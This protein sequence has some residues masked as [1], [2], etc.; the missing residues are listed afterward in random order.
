MPSVGRPHYP[1]R[2]VVIRIAAVK[3]TKGMNVRRNT[4]GRGLAAAGLGL[5]M[6]LAGCGGSDGGGSATA[7]TTAAAPAADGNA[8]T[9]KLI[10]FKPENLAVKAGATVTW[11]NEDGSDHTVTSGMVQQ[12][13][14]GVKAAPDGK[15]DSKSLGSGKTFS[16]TF[17]A[18]GTYSYYCNVHPATMRGEIKV[19]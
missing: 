14:G 10:A 9:L 3:R 6:L 11:K 13:S 19:T 18:P 8:V 16:F 17:A 12:Q 2:C 7:T 15:F 4:K 5:A 1:I